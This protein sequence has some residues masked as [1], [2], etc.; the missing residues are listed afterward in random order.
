MDS[1]QFDAA[2]ARAIETLPLE[3]QERLDNVV[4]SV[5]QGADSSLL[6]ELEAEELFGVYIGTPLTERGYHDTF[7]LP[8]QILLFQGPLAAACETEEEL[9]EEIR[10][11]LVHEIGHFFGLS[12]DEIEEAL[13]KPHRARKERTLDE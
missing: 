6:E 2:V 7:L 11:T 1:Q 4:I 9:T 3:F 5:Q 12:E 13:E 8:D 10:V